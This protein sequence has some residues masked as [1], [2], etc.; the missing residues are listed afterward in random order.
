[1]SELAWLE[2]LVLL[3]MATDQERARYRALRAER[4]PEE[5]AKV[6]ALLDRLLADPAGTCAEIREDR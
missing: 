5:D 1:M 4:A 3:Q 2:A 6:A